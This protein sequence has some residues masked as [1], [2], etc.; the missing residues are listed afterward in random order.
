MEQVCASHRK[1]RIGM[2]PSIDTG[3]VDPAGTMGTHR[4]FFLI[5]RGYLVICTHIF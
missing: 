1:N 5:F 3:D 2:A 4:F